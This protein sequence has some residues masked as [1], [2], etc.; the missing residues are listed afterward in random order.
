MHVYRLVTKGTVE[1]RILRRARQKES[2]QST[3]YGG[4]M[5][6]DQFTTRDVVDMIIDDIEDPLASLN[7]SEVKGFIKTGK[8]EKKRRKKKSGKETIVYDRPDRLAAHE[9]FEAE[10][11]QL[12][13]RMDF[14]PVDLEDDEVVEEA[15]VVDDEPLITDKKKLLMSMLD[16]AGG[17]TN[18]RFE[19]ED[20]DAVAQSAANKK[21]KP[22]KRGRPKKDGDAIMEEDDNEDYGSEEED[23]EGNAPAAGAD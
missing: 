17:K 8:S 7:K 23:L 15:P 6:T 16:Q 2:V 22:K 1:E 19:E 4:Q 14:D 9:K 12:L 10:A 11:D 18:F 3:V 13:R 21:E 5:K 20:A